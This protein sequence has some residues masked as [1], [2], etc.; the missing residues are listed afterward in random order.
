MF[1]HT[2]IPLVVTVLGASPSDGVPW[3]EIRQAR[4]ALDVYAAVRDLAE[5]DLGTISEKDAPHWA[6]LRIDADEFSGDGLP[7]D[8]K[9]KFRGGTIN[10]GEWER[11][12]SLIPSPDARRTGTYDWLERG[13][14]K[15]SSRFSGAYYPLYYGGFILAQH[16]PEKKGKEQFGT[17]VV[18]SEDTAKWVPAAYEFR[19]KNA[20]LFG[21]ELKQEQLVKLLGD[22][23]PMIAI[24]AAQRLATSQPFA[25]KALGAALDG[26]GDFRRPVAIYLAFASRD[27]NQDVAY[28]VRNPSDGYVPPEIASAI[29]KADAKMLRL[30]AI[31]IAAVAREKTGLTTNQRTALKLCRAQAETLHLDEKLQEELSDIFEDAELPRLDSK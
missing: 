23:N 24:M 22:E 21:K 25:G 1:I 8:P 5:F 27:P 4:R 7:D 11:M 10:K 26:P 19:H 17:L 14:L 29:A 28:S 31:A 3:T 30:Y 15:Q 2:M 18:L 13:P 12:G 20:D 6:I 16:Y 9:C